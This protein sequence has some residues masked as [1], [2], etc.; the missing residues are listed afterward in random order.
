MGV[1]YYMNIQQKVNELNRISLRGT[2]AIILMFAGFFGGGLL[3]VWINPIFMLLGF[4]IMGIGIYFLRGTVYNYKT[5]YKQVVIEKPLE[6]S[7]DNLH[8]DWTSGFSEETVKSFEVC[9]MGNRFYSEDLIQASYLGIPFEMSDVTVKYHSPSNKHPKIFFQG[10]ILVLDLPDNNINSVYILSKTFKNMQNIG[11]TIQS[12]TVNMDSNDFNQNFIVKA[13]NPHDAYYLLTPHFM[14]H[15]TDLSKRFKSII[16]HARGNKLVLALD[17]I[18]TDSFDSDR[19]FKRINYQQEIAKINKE[20]NDIK[21]IITVIRNLDA[22]NVSNSYESYSKLD[23]GSF[24][25]EHTGNA[26]KYSG[27]KIL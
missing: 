7:F 21:A 6:E 2:F 13:T 26:Y 23:S 11:K 20:I 17:D 5:L 10:R 15:I 19:I 12:Q 1:K 18:N 16:I 4:L 24:I 25:I 3:M 22:N 9:R 27:D 8:Y 14:E